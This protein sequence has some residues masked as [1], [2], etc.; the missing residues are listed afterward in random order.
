MKALNAVGVSVVTVFE[1][2]SDHADYFSLDQGMSDAAAALRAGTG[3]AGQPA[4]SP[5]IYF[6]GGLLDASPDEVENK[7]DPYFPW[8]WQG[9]GRQIQGSAAT[10]RGWCW[11]RWRRG[12]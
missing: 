10:A 2:A 11:G 5:V 7:V 6:A 12:R 4:M 3:A 9:A 1:A 8:R